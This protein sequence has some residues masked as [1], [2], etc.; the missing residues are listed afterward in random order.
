MKAIT[1]QRIQLAGAALM[2]L[3][4]LPAQAQEED[5]AAPPKS[6]PALSVRL[7]AMLPLTGLMNINAGGK[8]SQFGI[9]VAGISLGAELWHLGSVEA[10]AGAWFRSIDGLDTDRFVRVGVA[11]MIVDWRDPDGQGWTLQCD[12]LAGYRHLRRVSSPDGHDGTE[13]TN[14]VTGNVG[15]EWARFFSSRGALVLRLLT[16]VTVPRTQTRTGYWASHTYVS[17]PDDLRYLVDL[18]FNI[19][20][21]F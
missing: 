21:A 16:G 8:G 2:T 10:G 5:I 13:E 12:A 4:A 9:V 15:F 3:I 11:P 20:V 17:T 1:P 6:D 7:R 19:G 18:S 14:G